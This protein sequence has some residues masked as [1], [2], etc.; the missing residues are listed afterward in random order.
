MMWDLRALRSPSREWSHIVNSWAVL[1]WL[2][3]GTRRNWLRL[4]TR[5]AQTIFNNST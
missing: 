4:F 5:H 1:L 2:C 3:P